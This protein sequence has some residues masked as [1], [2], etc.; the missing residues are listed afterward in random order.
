MVL[1]E[2][3]S[4]MAIL[5]LEEEEVALVKAAGIKR[6]THFVTASSDFEDG[7]RQGWHESQRSQQRADLSALVLRMAEQ[8]AKS[9]NFNS[10]Q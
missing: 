6:F 9:S 3:E 2:F 1:S 10:I 7:V 5:G 8:P 4:I